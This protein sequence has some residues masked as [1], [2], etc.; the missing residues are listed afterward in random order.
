MVL[1]DLN[2]T[3]LPLEKVDQVGAALKQVVAAGVI[4]QFQ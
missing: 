4:N 3:Y 2:N 1:A